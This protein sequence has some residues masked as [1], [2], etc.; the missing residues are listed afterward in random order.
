MSVAPKVSDFMMNLSKELVEK[1][2]VAE[3]SAN[4]YV[5]TLYLLNDKVAFKTLAF[6]RN[7]DVVL[8]RIEAYAP[9]TQ[10]SILAS[11][12]SVLSLVKDKPTYKAVYKFFYDKMMEKAKPV[13]EAAASNEKTDKQKE[14]WVSWK[15]VSDLMATYRNKMVEYGAK[16]TITPSEYAHLLQAL[17]LGL[18]TYTQPRRNQDYLDMAVVKKWREDM[19]KDKNYL[20]LT[21]SRFVFNKYKTA[22]KYGTQIMAIPN[23]TEAPLLDTIMTYLK[24]HPL[25]KASKG[26]EAVH[27]LVDAE[28]KALTAVNAITRLLNRIFGKRVG[29][30]ML[31]HIFLSDKYDI[32]EMK[33]DAAAMGHSLNE[34][35][36]YMRVEG[37]NMIVSVDGDTIPELFFPAE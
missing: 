29:S 15:E 32:E 17:V 20:D 22:K 26:K 1:K 21:G 35:K 6:L 25:W 16:K 4:A 2:G 3:S 8:Q 37:G 23:T 33:E 11:V 10:K 30:S 9:S 7:K 36:K 28:G 12:V 13:A 14:N 5:K 24:F 31:R 34:Q 27:F 19:P 18:Y